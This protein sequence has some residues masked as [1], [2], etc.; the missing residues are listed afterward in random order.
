[1][2]KRQADHW[3]RLKLFMKWYVQRHIG[4]GDFFNWQQRTS[5][6]AR[7]CPIFMSNVDARLCLILYEWQSMGSRADQIWI[8]RQEVLKL[9]AAING[10]RV[11]FRRCRIPGR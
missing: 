1:M 3:R 2:N 11:P 8:V 6:Y 4:D 7:N 10:H 9:W 5:H